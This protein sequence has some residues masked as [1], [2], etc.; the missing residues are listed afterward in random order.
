MRAGTKGGRDGR[1]GGRAWEKGCAGTDGCGLSRIRDI[2]YTRVYRRRG[3]RRE[4]VGTGVPRA[5]VQVRG[6]RWPVG[7]DCGGLAG[8]L[9]DFRRKVGLPYLFRAFVGCRGV[10]GPFAGMGVREVGRDGRGGCRTGVGRGRGGEKG[11]R[12]GR[13]DTQSCEGV[14]VTWMGWAE[15]VGEGAEGGR[16]RYSGRQ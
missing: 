1:S 6:E 2:Y 5:E 16:M 9:R 15:R 3:G 11:R 13:R 14:R 4:A 7:G 8:V 12:G 10:Y